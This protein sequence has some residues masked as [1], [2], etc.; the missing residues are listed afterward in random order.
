MIPHCDRPL[1]TTSQFRSA[2]RQILHTFTGRT[3]TDKTKANR[4]SSR[5]AKQPSVDNGTRYVLCYTERPSP[6]AI[7]TIEFILWSQGVTAKS[8]GCAVGVRG[9]CMI[10]PKK[11]NKNV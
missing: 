1:A 5:Y 3:Y 8:R 2:V 6:K 7:E 9:T 4:P 10:S 11:E